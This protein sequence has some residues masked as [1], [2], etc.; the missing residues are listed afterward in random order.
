MSE[1]VTGALLGSGSEGDRYED[2]VPEGPA[3]EVVDAA[4]GDLHEDHVPASQPDLGAAPEHDVAEQA[5]EVADDGL[6]DGLDDHDS[7]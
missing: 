2:H 1:D 5:A 7:A 4:E 3:G 6:D